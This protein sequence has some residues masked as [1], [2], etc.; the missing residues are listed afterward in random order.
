MKS[1]RIRPAESAVLAGEMTNIFKNFSSLPE[2]EE[3]D[4]KTLA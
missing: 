1:E 4:W 2:R 3:T